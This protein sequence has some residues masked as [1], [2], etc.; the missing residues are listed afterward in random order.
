MKIYGRNVIKELLISDNTNLIKNIYISKEA[1]GSM[2]Q[3]KE[4]IKAKGLN[5]SEIPGKTMDNVLGLNVRH[6]GIYADID[7]FEY[8]AEERYAADAEAK[9]E[10]FLIIL[11]QV[12][13]PQN[14]GAII[15]T[16]YGAGADAVV[17]TKDNSAQVNPTVIKVSTGLAFNIPIIR[18]VNLARFLDIIKDSGFWIYSADMDGESYES[19]DWDQKTALVFGN[20]GKGI[21]RL[22]GE[23]CDHTVSIPMKREMDSL[24]LSVSV[25]VL[26]FSVASKRS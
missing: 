6:Q 14:F 16:A 9:S 8:Y 15:R 24:N 18:T 11:D 13:D 5:F 26:A 23:K 10:G 22:V 2:T 25:G 20:E 1:H 21:R 7:E 4:D 17:I 12:N 3:I 19:V